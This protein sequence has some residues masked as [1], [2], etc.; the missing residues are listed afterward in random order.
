MTNMKSDFRI[1]S[2]APGR[3]ALPLRD[4]PPGASACV[5]GLDADGHDRERLEVMGLC[6]GRTVDVVKGGDPMIV[7]VLGTR[8]G[9]AG[10]LAATVRVAPHD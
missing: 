2:G 3:G 1:D 6:E 4:L 5:V 7:R 8:I 9:L 10:R